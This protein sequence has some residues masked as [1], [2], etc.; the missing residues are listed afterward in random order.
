MLFLPFLFSR[1]LSSTCIRKETI[2]GFI[3]QVLNLSTPIEVA[4]HKKRAPS[5]RELRDPTLGDGEY[6]IVTASAGDTEIRLEIF[7]SGNDCELLWIEAVDKEWTYQKPKDEDVALAHRLLVKDIG[8]FQQPTL[9]GYV[10]GRTKTVPDGTV[11][12]IA[13]KIRLYGDVSIHRVGFLRATAGDVTFLSS[14][15]LMTD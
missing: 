15:P 12:E 8:S 10:F 7:D 6:S 5:A 13:V 4:F 2:E 3:H 9:L 11:H 14:H 1:S